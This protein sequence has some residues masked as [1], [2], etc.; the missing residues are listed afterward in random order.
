MGQNRST[1]Y[2]FC[3]SEPGTGS[4]MQVSVRNT[5]R[6]NA[7]L[8]QVP[9]H[10]HSITPGIAST[11][12]RIYFHH[13]VRNR[14][15]KFCLHILEQGQ[16]PRL[17]AVQ[18]PH[19]GGIHGKWPRPDYNLSTHWSQVVGSD[20]KF[21]HIPKYPSIRNSASKNGIVRT[22][23]YNPGQNCWHIPPFNVV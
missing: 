10:V 9:L 11:L 15:A 4:T 1:E 18:L 7:V 17:S 21:N 22:A 2:G 20:R 16:V 13:L 8:G 14:V 12:E 23:I 3:L 5:L 6:T 19:T